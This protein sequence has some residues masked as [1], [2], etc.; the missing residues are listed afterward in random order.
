MA[1]RI[2]LN[3]AVGRIQH[4]HFRDGLAEKAMRLG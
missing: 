3:P 4:P 1:D 2:D